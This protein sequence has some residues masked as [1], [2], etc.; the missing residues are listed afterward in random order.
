M[1]TFMKNSVSRTVRV[2]GPA[3]LVNDLDP[4][5]LA[6]DLKIGTRSGV[7]FMPNKPLLA[8]G[9]RILPPPS[10]ASPIGDPPKATSAPSPPEEPPGVSRLLNG[11]KVRPYTI[12]ASVLQFEGEEIPI[13]TELTV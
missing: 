5:M 1:M 3:T 9:E 4:R 8:A 13:K 2:R 10:A 6:V 7:H 12:R 11:F